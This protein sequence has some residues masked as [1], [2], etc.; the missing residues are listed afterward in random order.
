M[1]L[2]ASLDHL[3][4]NDEPLGPYTWLG[5]GGPARYFAEPTDRDELCTLI[6]AA[7][8]AQI[9]IKMLGEGSNVLVRE[10]GFDGLVIHTAAASLGT[11]DVQGNRL[12]AGG[13]AKLSHAITRAVAE[14]LGGLERLAGIPGTIGGAVVGNASAGGA[15]IGSVVASVQC[16]NADGTTQ[17]RDRTEVQFSHRKSDLAGCFVL[18]VTFELEPADTV[19]LTKW[20]QKTWIVRRASRPSEHSRIA[21]P[22]VDPDGADAANLIEQVGLKGSRRGGASLDSQHPAYMIA[23]PGATSDDCLELLE[24]VRDQVSKQ[25]AVDLQL[26]LVIW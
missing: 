21:L 12:I 10:A 23:H 17:I 18:Q 9:P 4:R 20:L 3:V 7:E 5:I 8:E 22:L 11:L 26:N 15:E 19:E 2:P 25:L 13:G 1:P 14:G 16:V 24:L 6:R